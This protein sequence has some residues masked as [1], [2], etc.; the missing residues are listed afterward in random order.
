MFLCKNAEI[1]AAY[2]E[3]KKKEIAAALL[4]C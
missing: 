3:K 2:Q 4:K 1:A